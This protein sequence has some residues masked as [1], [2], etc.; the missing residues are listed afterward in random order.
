[1]KSFQHGVF[2]R[3]LTDSPA[4]LLKDLVQAFIRFSCAKRQNSRRKV[5]TFPDG[6]Q[7]GNFPNDYDICQLAQ[8]MGIMKPD[9]ESLCNQVQ[10]H[11]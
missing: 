6:I 3:L 5:S 4:A 8:W 1:M 2:L 11:L 10:K 7:N 9:L